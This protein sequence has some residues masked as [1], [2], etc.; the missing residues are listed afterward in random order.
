MV[1]ISKKGDRGVAPQEADLVC[2]GSTASAP[3]QGYENEDDG[4]QIDL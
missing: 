1:P 4:L 3:L 2:V